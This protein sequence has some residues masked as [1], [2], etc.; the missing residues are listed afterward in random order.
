MIMFFAFLTVFLVAPDLAH[1][2]G[3]EVAF[4]TWVVGTFGVTALQAA[5][6]AS[7]VTNL[8]IGTALSLVGQL[9][10]KKPK[11]IKPTGIQT[12]QTTAGDTTPQKFI[13]G[14]YAA[15]GHAVAPAYSRGNNNSILTYIIEVSNIPIEGLTGRIIIDGQYTDLTEGSD[16]ASRLDFAG[17]GFDD[18]GNPRGWL[19]FYDGTQTTAQFKLVES[20]A[21][22]PDRPWTTNHILEGTA[23]AVLEFPLNR[24]IY[25]GLPSVRFEVE[26]IRL[27]DPRKDTSVGGSGTHRF[28]TPSTWEYSGNPQVIN[29]NILRGITLPSGDIYGGQVLAEDLPLDNWFA[30]MNECDVL[31]GDRKQ[32]VAGFEINTGAMEP[33]E[34]IEEMNRS[35]FAQI[36]EFGGVFR[37]RVGAP[38][39]PVMSLTDDDFMITEPASYDPFPGLQ[40]TFNAIT[41]TYVEPADVWEGRSADAILNSTWETDDGGR[42]LTVDVGL[43]AVSSKSQAQQLLTAYIKDQRRFRVHRMVL[44]PSFALLEP[45]D[46]ISWTS[47]ANGYTSKV[48]E[49]TAVE[50]RPNTLNQF[51][52][53]REREAADVA[54]D[55]DNEASVPTVVSWANLTPPGSIAPT[56]TATPI[57]IQDNAGN[58]RQAAIKLNWPDNEAPGVE[59]LEW[60]SRVILI[61]PV[62]RNGFATA[63]DGQTVITGGIV[64]N[65]NYEVRARYVTPNWAWSPWISVTT[66]ETFISA[67]DMVADIRAEIG[68][69]R[70]D[71]VG[72]LPTSGYAAGDFV[73]LT[74]DSKLY[75]FDGTDW[76]A[77]AADTIIAPGS[78]TVEKIAA[79]SITTP[80][81]QANAV[82]VEKIAAGSITTPK[83]QANAVTG[84]KIADGSITTPKIQANSITANEISAGAVTAT[85]ITAGAIT[86]DKIA[87]NAI[88][89]T[90]IQAGAITSEKIDA[91]AITSVKIATNAITAVK[92]TAGAITADKIATNAI[93]ATKIDAQAITTEKIATNAITS[94]KITAGAITATQLDTNSVTSAKIATN[95]II[96]G[97]ISAGAVSADK[98]AVDTIAA[99][100]ANLGSITA[101]SINTQSGGTGIRV[102]SPPF[103]NA[104]YS[105]QRS[106]SAYSLYAVNS[107]TGG[108]AGFIRSA[109]GFTLQVLNTRNGSG[110][111]G[112]YVAMDVQNTA[113]GGGNASI[114]VSSAGGGY[115]VHATSGGFYAT[116]GGYNPFTGCHDGMVHKTA[117]YDL[118]DIMVDHEIISR[119]L[120][121]VFTELKPSSSLNQ[122][123]AVGIV[124]RTFDK[125]HLPAA[126]INQEA[127]DAEKSRL[128]ALEDN[129]SSSDTEIGRSDKPG[130]PVVITKFDTESFSETYNLIHINSVGEG[131]VNVCGRGGD[132]DI[133]DL[134]TTSSLPGK[135]QR[136]ADDIVRNYTVAKAREATT[137]ADPD[138]VKM[139]P[140]IY[141]CG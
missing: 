112:P 43:P 83:L 34:V 42:R 20:Y 18:A 87:T 92:I 131:S 73:Y 51:V 56:L 95:A 102:N 32:Y 65:T 68:A 64:P 35:S 106:T 97:K 47:T 30:A 136:Q 29:Y 85:K 98:I 139:V 74:T 93:V 21:S 115:G 66:N 90:K 71:V 28:A 104:F 119:G 113:S 37:V 6:I 133:G 9:F 130:T 121:D 40:N 82:T 27:Y 118:G 132:L 94:V 105:F 96:A 46:T 61:D 109:G 17:L 72:A 4:A 110:S 44:P 116:G 129:D 24:E 114:G 19:W 100:N 79:G 126:F 12:E 41:G 128:Q 10:T 120:M 7:F 135:G 76:T 91:N 103:N 59:L 53:V 140:C 75:E 134:I 55:S 125:W 22:H 117:Q 38:A 39:S 81:L 54:W 63:S 48:F 111:F 25:T 108:G 86:A 45:L 58:P 127:T 33:V 1:A 16:D 57:I 3:L 124:S 99:I 62:Q 89:A 52:T 15:E 101:G 77:V 60:E 122:K 8:V 23:Y 69:A 5:A 138:E 123:S 84:T 107:T 88:V 49:I 67:I 36:S 13:V 141:L 31:I 11:G 26:G 80:K 78:V 2:T 137:F 50:D 14:T 70:V